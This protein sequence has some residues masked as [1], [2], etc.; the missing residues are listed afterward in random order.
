M[1]RRSGPQKELHV[2]GSDFQGPL[3][4]LQHLLQ[5]V[6]EAVELLLCLMAPP[7]SSSRISNLLSAFPTH[8]LLFR[9]SKA[10]AI[11]ACLPFDPFEFALL[12][13]SL[14]RALT[15]DVTADS[16]AC[17]LA[18]CGL[19]LD[20]ALIDLAGHACWICPEFS[21]PAMRVCPPALF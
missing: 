1:Q 4:P 16:S 19:C 21:A 7:R 3:L 12:N 6:R 14:P 10:N 8:L 11:E 20:Q 15:V 2:D 17:S 9:V 13:R 5:E 18:C